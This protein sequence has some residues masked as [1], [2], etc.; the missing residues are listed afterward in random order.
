M[1][2][3]PGRLSAVLR[4]FGGGASTPGGTDIFA[5]LPTPVLVIDKEDRIRIANGAAEALFNRG[6][7]ALSQTTLGEMVPQIAD[8]LARSPGINADDPAIAVYDVG[9]EPVEGREHRADLLISPIAD[10]PGW[11]VVAVHAR[12]VTSL[13]D[14]QVIGKGAARS[15]IGAAA[16]LAHEIKNPL[17]GIRGAAQLLSRSV[18]EGGEALTRLIREEVD[19][20][21]ALVDR[22][23]GFTD[24]R[25]VAFEAQNIHAILGHVREIAT[26][27]FARELTIRELYDPSLPEV[28]GNRDML[29]QIFLNLVK[30]AAE[31][32]GHN[33]ASDEIVLTTAYRHGYSVTDRLGQ[34]V[35]LPI[36]VCVFDTGPGAPP[37]VAPHMFDP[38]VSSKKSGSGLGLPLVAKLV[39]DHGGV[40]EYA[41]EGRPQRTVFRVLLPRYTGPDS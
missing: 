25:P 20:I 15:A 19:R 6:Q 24:D 12:A 30:N 40:I 8:A 18:G 26:S 27:G 11:R 14:R 10:H 7:A 36:E 31:A 23:E 5:S 17:S 13:L 37:D 35:A 29:I 28:R 16:M 2:V 33:T 22:M 1:A 32:L 21:A 38:F 34:R 41:R 39:A 4:P 9:F 3:R